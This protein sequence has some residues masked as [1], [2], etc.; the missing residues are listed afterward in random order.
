M[1]KLY[2]PGANTGLG[3]Y[4]RFDGILSPWSRPHYKYILK[5]GPGVG[6][7]TLM[8]KVTRR[9]AD[10]GYEVEEFR[11]ASDPNSLDA[12][13]IPA[14]GLILLDGTAPHAI[15]P[16]LPGIEGEILD[17]GR[18]EKRD[19]FSEHR[20]ELE[21]LF[22]NNKACYRKAYALLGAART[23]HN[24]ALCE[25][26]AILDRAAVNAYLAEHL[27]CTQAGEH[28]VL[29]TVSATPRG[30]IDYSETHLPK[31]CTRVSG[32]VGEAIL[33]IAGE[34]VQGKRAEICCGF[35]DPERPYSIVTEEAA[36]AVTE[37]GDKAEHLCKAPLCAHAV[38]CYETA[39]TLAKKA[40]ETLADALALHDRI[41]AIYRPFVDYNHVDRE[42]DA[43]LLRLGI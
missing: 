1:T 35:I 24:E 25:A 34:H 40:C 43:L 10:A 42:S 2:F 7:N 13:R 22:A 5:G 9:A 11:C 3:F 30:I 20:G 37:N 19:A 18:F 23:L 36:L 26:E 33:S 12:I 28:R 27:P 21:K 4:S 15:D 29:F 38:Y 31:D 14:L 41:E 32:L 6:K 39:R 17:L 16:F 8:R